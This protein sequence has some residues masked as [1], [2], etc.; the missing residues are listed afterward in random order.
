[1]GTQTSPFAPL[2]PLTGLPVVTASPADRKPFAL[3]DRQKKDH[4]VALPL[5]SDAPWIPPSLNGLNG[6]Q[7]GGAWERINVSQRILDWNVE[8]TITGGSTV[9]LSV[10][11]PDLELLNSGLLDERCKIRLGGFVFEL[12]QCQFD[13]Q[14]RTLTISFEDAVIAELR[15]HTAYKAWKAGTISAVGVIR[16]FLSEKVKGLPPLPGVRLYAPTDPGGGLATL[17]PQTGTSA[18]AALAGQ[19]R[20]QGLAN[21]QITI[22]GTPASSSQVDNCNAVIK[23]AIA[24][25]NSHSDSKFPRTTTAECVMCIMTILAE[26]KAVNLP[27]GDADSE[28]LFQQRPSQGWTGLTNRVLATQQF[29]QHLRVIEEN[30]AYN[31]TSLQML[32]QTVQRSNVKDGSNYAAYEGDAKAI[33]SAFLGSSQE[34]GLSAAGL[35]PNEPD[36][37]G[38]ASGKPMTFHR[39]EKHTPEDSWTA[40]QRIAKQV[41]YRCFVVGDILY[42]VGDK[43][44][45]ASESRLSINAGTIGVSDVSFDIDAG[46]RTSE[47]DV[48]IDVKAWSIPPGSVVTLTSL[49]PAN[50]DWIVDTVSADGKKT[51]WLTVKLTRPKVPLVEAG[52]DSSALPGGNAGPIP[53]A[54]TRYRTDAGMVAAVATGSQGRQKVV[55]AALDCLAK[56]Y[57]VTDYAQVRPF[58]IPLRLTPGPVQL[59]DCSAFATEVYNLA[60][61]PDPN[62]LGYDGNGSTRTLIARGTLVL[63]PQPGDLVFFGSAAAPEHVAV[64]IG[65]GEVIEIGERKAIGGGI[66]RTTIAI[67]AAYKNRGVAGYRSYV[68]D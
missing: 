36:L 61:E 7:L 27:G 59:I 44:L 65:N 39:G 3:L 41:N 15:R 18:P 43:R 57:A 48:V 62:G 66:K 46:K 19:K 9:T 68:N 6:L 11:D 23:A 8:S 64:C 26:S 5:P 31:G 4:P 67:E 45:L 49:G 51:S 53:A 42:F 35:G 14:T 24:Y 21:Q 55:A 22:G 30:S 2:D 16:W 50:G 38:T 54:T 12:V 56:G 34:G 63:Q 33:V 47:V 40:M 32:I 29:M 60:G 10:H 37:A 58:P 20:D 13:S 25:G 28:G 17:Q 1:M 52:N